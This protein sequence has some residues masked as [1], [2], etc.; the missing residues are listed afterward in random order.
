MADTSVLSGLDL[1]KW[2]KQFIRESMRDS[3]FE[4]YMGSSPTDII[5][6]VNDINAEGYTIRVPLVKRLQSNGVSGNT[7]LSGNEEALDQYYQDVSWEYYRNAIEVSKKERKKSAVDLLAVRR[8]LL[9]EWASELIKYE[10]IE[11][12][13]T[14]NGTA[15][16]SASESAKDAWLAANSTRVQFGA[17]VSN[18]Q[19]NDHSASLA[20]ID[21]TN[22]KLTASLIT[23]I[24]RRARYAS[25]HIK[26]FKTGTMGREYYVLFTHPLCFRDLKT[27]STIAQANREARPRE[28]GSNPIFQDGDLIYDGVIIREIPEFYQPRFDTD[29]VNTDTHL[30]DVGDSSTVDVGVNFLCG[31]NAMAMVNKQA[32][33]PISKKEDDYG[34]FDGVGVEMAHGFAKMRWANGANSTAA[35]DYGMMT[36]Y[37]A[38]QPD[39]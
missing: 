36:V 37:C 25:P 30:E 3:G 22:D 9:K 20:T 8:P 31:Q 26:P 24:K 19:S 4:P 34:F 21:A 16:T 7:R 38:A 11:N 18:N 1:T 33:L 15:Y 23:L 39:T 32:A 13:H 14:I 29:T 6:V 35:I 10:I 2:R 12:F 27:D 28:V 5:Q 17:S